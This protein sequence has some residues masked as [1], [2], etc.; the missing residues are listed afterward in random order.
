MP[1]N[2]DDDRSID[3]TAD[4]K[5]TRRDGRRWVRRSVAVAT[6]LVLAVLALYGWAWSSVDRSS[7]ARAMWWMEA[8]IGDQY[9]FPTRPIPAGDDPSPLPAGAELDLPAP[10]VATAAGGAALDGFLRRT[11]TLA[12]LVVHDDRM[13]YER[14]FGGADRRTLQTSFSVAKSFVSTLVG[15][16]IDEGLIHSVSDPVT[17]YV[18]ELAKRDPRFDRITLRDLL[19]MSSGIRYEEHSLPLPWGDDVN[20]YYGTDLRDLA[21]SETEIERPPG[22]QWLYNNYNPLLLG[23]VL[24]RA[25]GMSVS[26]YMAT[27]LWQPLGSEFDA[28]WSLDSERSGF[29]KM[30]SGLNAAPVDYARFG[31]LFIHNGE[32]NGTRIVSEEWVRAA[33]AADA[34][35]D[36]A[37]HYQFF[38]WIDTERP[39]RFY[40]LG[41][42][43]QYIYVAPD[44]RTVIVRNGRDWGVD[45]G[46]WLAAF[47]EI[48]DRLAERS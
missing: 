38:W 39:G 13:V 18:P 24:E 43:G 20:T 29:E 45:N 33:T 35:G 8:D 11:E 41:N 5:R 40:A 44:A 3:V 46:T 26:E 28:T 17:E 48:A 7:I 22:Q 12:F 27:R 14:Y 10:A 15:I 25:T 23:L 19:A 42:F 36:P 31:E 34:T 1:P 30:E 47:R 9:R 6:A 21:L 16:A 2:A 37:E 4:R 32:W